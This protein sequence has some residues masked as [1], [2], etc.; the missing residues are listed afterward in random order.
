MLE[1]RRVVIAYR[2]GREVQIGNT[3]PFFRRPGQQGLVHVDFAYYKGGAKTLF[4]VDEGASTALITG[5]SRRVWQG[6]PKTILSTE[7]GRMQARRIGVQFSLHKTLTSAEID[8]ARKIRE[9]PL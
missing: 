9:R 5:S 6:P 2:W 4:Y 7:V 3:A 8:T 1:W